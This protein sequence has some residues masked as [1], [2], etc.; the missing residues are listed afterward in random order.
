[1]KLQNRRRAGYDRPA[2]PRQDAVRVKQLVGKIRGRFVATI[3]VAI[4]ENFDSSFGRLAWSRSIRVVEHFDHPKP[5][6][7]VKCHGHRTLNLRLGCYQFDAQPRRDLEDGLSLVRREWCLSRF[8]WRYIGGAE[9]QPAAGGQKA[10]ERYE[11]PHA[12]Q[13]RSEHEGQPIKVSGG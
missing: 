9:H 5:A 2:F 4:F 7:L 1:A 6:I 12:A 8:G 11:K 3:A 13:T 10:C